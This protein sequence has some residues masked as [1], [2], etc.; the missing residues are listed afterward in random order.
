MNMP[1]PVAELFKYD[2]PFKWDSR[3]F[4]QLAWCQGAEDESNWDSGAKA[5]VAKCGTGASVILITGSP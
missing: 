1:T 3:P 5:L 4:R 2:W